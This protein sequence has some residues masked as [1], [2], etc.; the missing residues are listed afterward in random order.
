MGVDED[1]E[2]DNDDAETDVDHLL[3]HDAVWG[4]IE[5]LGH[6]SRT[7]EHLT[8]VV[9]EVA[10]SLH[11]CPCA[12]GGGAVCLVGK[13]ELIQA[14]GLSSEDDHNPVHQLDHKAAKSHTAV[15]LATV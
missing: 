15:V 13:L 1:E 12:H 10:Y 4:E 11:H 7:G 5:G 2:A 6:V 14:E 8:A 3:E 9:D